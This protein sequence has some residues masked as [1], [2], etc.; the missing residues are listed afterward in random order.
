MGC[1]ELE[2]GKKL[3]VC[4]GVCACEYVRARVKAYGNSV[5]PHQHLEIV[6]SS[7]RGLDS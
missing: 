1:L 4:V 7:A 2:Q 3:C 5:R 6:V